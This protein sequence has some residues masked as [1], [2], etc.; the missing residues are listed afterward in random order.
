[1]TWFL[2]VRQEQG[3]LSVFDSVVWFE[4]FRSIPGEVGRNCRDRPRPSLLTPGPG[5]TEPASRPSALAVP[6]S[7]V[8]SAS[9]PGNQTVPHRWPAFPR[10][11]TRKRSV[12]NGM[13]LVS[14]GAEGGRDAPAEAREE[15]SL[16]SKGRRV[17]RGP[18]LE[19]RGRKLPG[20]G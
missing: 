11:S 18:A 1:M 4:A 15:T 10:G 17:S 16:Q 5:G 9:L 19:R 7:V 20:G 13:V 8:A 2:N 6:F 12:R 14:V 3:L